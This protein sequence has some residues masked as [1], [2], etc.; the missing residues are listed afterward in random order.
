MS[1]HPTLTAALADQHRRDMITRAET[2]R[3]AR[4]ARASRPAPARPAR[5][6]P[7]LTAAARRPLARLLPVKAPATAGAG[8]ES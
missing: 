1:M 4:A 5:I 2:H 6:I 3:I 7:R 8:S